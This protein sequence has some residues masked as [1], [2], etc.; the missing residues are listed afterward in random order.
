M[1]P[2]GKY[3]AGDKPRLSDKDIADDLVRHI[4][5]EFTQWPNCHAIFL[6]LSQSK[7]SIQK[8]VFNAFKMS[9]T[10]GAP[11]KLITDFD[12]LGFVESNKNMLQDQARAAGITRPITDLEAIEYGLSTS[13]SRY[14]RAPSVKF[15]PKLD[16]G[17]REIQ[18][19]RDAAVRA[20]R[21]AKS[22]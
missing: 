6:A 1:K 22:K 8:R 2:R 19:I 12:W 13:D 21:T 7:P 16:S 18:R 5:A 11:K 14:N 20:R 17:K 3:K 15:K 10:R 4:R 9:K